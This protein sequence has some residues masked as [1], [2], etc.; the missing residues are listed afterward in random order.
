MILHVVHPDLTSPG[1]R[2]A[3]P[4]YSA[5]VAELE[6]HLA[7]VTIRAAAVAAATRLTSEDALVLFNR[8]D[9]GYD[10][11][12]RSLFEEAAGAGLE[13]FPVALAEGARVPPSE[14]SDKQSFDVTDQLRRRNLDEINV[15]TVAVVLARAVV[16]RLQPTLCQ[17]GL[18]LFIS[19]KRSD[20]EAPAAAFHKLLSVRAH[21]SFRDLVD[22]RVGEDAQD[23]IEANLLRSDAVV[24][25]DTPKAGESAWVA[26]ELEMALSLNLPVVWVRIGPEEGRAP[27]RVRP[28]GAPHFTLAGGASSPDAVGPQFAD[29]VI[30]AAFRISRES[31]ARVF[32]RLRRLRRIAAEGK[33]Q[34]IEEDKNRLLFSV[35]IPRRG[36]RYPQR[37]ITHLVQLYGRWPKEADESDFLPFVGGL[38]YSPHPKHG[39][40]YDAALLIGPIPGQAFDA[41]DERPFYVDS[42]DEYVSTLEQYVRAPAPESPRRG[43]IISGSFPESQPEFQQQLTD[44]VHAFA[45]A[46]LNRQGVVIFGAHP[47]FTPLIFDMA[48]RQ[49]PRDFKAAVRMYASRFFAEEAA[50]AGY[51]KNATIMPTDAVAGRR[52]ESLTRM[53]RAMI[54]DG[55]AAGLVA[56]GGRTRAGGHSPGVDEEIRLARERGLPVYLIGSA[57]GRASELGAEMSAAGW[58]E[59]LNGLSAE[60]N[61][62]LLTSP[63]YGT[64]AN[65]ILDDLKI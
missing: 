7:V 48:K 49:R 12:L 57:G 32:D 13:V 5:L 56:V 43:L 29:E 20:G 62:E 44:A 41:A 27:L 34:L 4:F 60:Q 37:P 1:S 11:S 59:P 55:N 47:T 6:Q 15:R 3:E 25:L 8:P 19:H 54:E 2:L 58:V 61:R 63:D 36:F 45:R 38:G 23:V 21:E 65:V 14:L 16:S 30:H 39:P 18:R 31:A 9:D 64:L 33:I 22:V 42:L 26:R 51:A 10:A 24:F 17:E 52:D 28:S 53:R 35:R 50:L 40:F 46:T